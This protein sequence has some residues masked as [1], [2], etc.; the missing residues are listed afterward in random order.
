MSHSQIKIGNQS[1]NRDGEYSVNIEHL[2]NVTASATD[3][4]ILK[5]DGN[6][7]INAPLLGQY[8]QTNGIAAGWSTYN[9]GAGSAYTTTGSLDSYR[10][11]TYNNWSGRTSDTYFETG[12]ITMNRTTHGGSTPTQ[13]RFSRVEL[14]A[15]G[16]YI[17]VA[18]TKVYNTSSSSYIEWQWLDIATD[19]PLSAR[20][21]QYG[22]NVGDSG[23]C[24][25]YVTVTGGSRICDIRCISR[26]GGS[27]GATPYV[28]I[29][30]AF[31]IG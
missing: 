27:D 14:N 4:T 30:G 21:R 28:D 6:N 25:G 5:F 16:K 22:G 2:N 13:T 8:F 3:D 29:I 17:L 23:Y 1:A 7:W 9:G 26:T 31:Q 20:W 15:N 24:I 10:T 11:H 19:D 18:N 12:N